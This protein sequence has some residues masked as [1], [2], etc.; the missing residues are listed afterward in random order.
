MY[1]RPSAAELLK[2]KV[3][4]FMT[5]NEEGSVNLL[6]TIR[7]P[8]ILSLIQQKWPGFKSAD[9]NTKI[10]MKKDSLLYKPKL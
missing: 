1:E 9:K 6:N 3:F 4:Q 2:D 7:C 10:E 5:T 8:K